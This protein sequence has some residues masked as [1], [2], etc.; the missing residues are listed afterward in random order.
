MHIV[1]QPISNAQWFSERMIYH[2]DVFPK[3]RKRRLCGRYDAGIALTATSLRYLEKRI[4]A[5]EEKSCDIVNYDIKSLSN[6]S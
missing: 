2:E 6:A 3:V 1:T 5:N 4:R